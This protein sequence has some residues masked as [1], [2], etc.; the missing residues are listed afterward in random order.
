VLRAPTHIPRTLGRPP[1]LLPQSPQEHASLAA[2]VPSA[3]GESLIFNS[4][5]A[6][7]SHLD[8]VR[9][10][11]LRSK[12][13]ELWVQVSTELYVFSED[14]LCLAVQ[15][16]KLLT[17][18]RTIIRGRLLQELQRE[19]AA[20]APQE[21]KEAEAQ[22]T[23]KPIGIM[24]RDRLLLAL[25]PPMSLSVVLPAGVQSTN[26]A[27]LFAAINLEFDI[28]PKNL[29]IG[30]TEGDDDSTPALIVTFIVK[31]QWNSFQC[32][33][34]EDNPLKLTDKEMKGDELGRAGVRICD[35]IASVL[36]LCLYSLA[37]CLSLY[38]VVTTR[39]YLYPYMHMRMCMCM[40]N[41]CTCA[42]VHVTCTCA[43]ACTCTHAHACACACMCMCMCDRS[44]TGR[45][46][47][48]LRQFP[49]PARPCNQEY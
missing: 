3:T 49:L 31:M 26:I 29:S 27:A 47:R 6:I 20:R 7:H 37:P 1:P 14:Q 46:S 19:A 28:N 4:L 41:R 2:D 38:L 9:S 24:Q 22:K 18:L 13:R 36:Y 10:Q 43:C 12:A 15:N 5:L 44:H 45:S 30:K 34:S 40:C 32:I 8:D 23:P 25:P 48:T 11:E 33:S 42:H 35:S 21:T 39:E 16:S 17:D